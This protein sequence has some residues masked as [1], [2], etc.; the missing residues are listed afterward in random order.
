[1]VR[2]WFHLSGIFESLSWLFQF[3][4]DAVPAAP[5]N[6][7]YEPDGDSLRS[8]EFHLPYACTLECQ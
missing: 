4:L 3:V 2:V 6:L 8:C 7:E 5:L 1:M